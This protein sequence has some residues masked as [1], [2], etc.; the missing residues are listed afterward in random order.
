MI[1]GKAN[2]KMASIVARS[3]SAENNHFGISKGTPIA[4][5]HLMSIIAYCDM[6]R[7]STKFS[8]TFRKLK[9]EETMKSV[10]QRNR[11]YWWQSKLLK[12]AVQCYG[13]LGQYDLN[14]LPIEKTEF[15]SSKQSLTI[16]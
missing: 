12:E 4:I 7:Y 10:K 15:S 11:N 14:D 5:D 8:S 2:R 6:D 9:Q 3:M 1:Y 16:H 13:T